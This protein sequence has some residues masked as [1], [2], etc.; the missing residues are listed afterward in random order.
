MPACAL[1]REIPALKRHPALLTH[2]AT[3]RCSNQRQAISQALY[4]WKPDLYCIYIFFHLHRSVEVLN[5]EIARNAA[6]TLNGR[7]SY[8]TSAVEV[9]EGAGDLRSAGNLGR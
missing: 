7:R 4:S 3:T 6:Q 9:L 8:D 2:T 5:D 1:Q